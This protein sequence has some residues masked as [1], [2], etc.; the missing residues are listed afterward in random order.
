MG[1][2]VQGLIG[3]EDMLLMLDTTV[4]RRVV[5]KLIEKGKELKNLA[6]RMA[7][8]DDANLEKAIKM[9]P[10]GIDGGRERDETGRFIRTEIEIYVDMDMPVPG[11]PGKTVGDYAYEIHEHLSPMGGLNLGDKSNM[12]QMSS[13]DVLVGGGFMTRAAEQIETGLDAAFQQALNQTI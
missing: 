13:P 11:R 9:R 4:K 10:E 1:V 7:P 12:K 5:R 8:V 2:T 3:A 6:I